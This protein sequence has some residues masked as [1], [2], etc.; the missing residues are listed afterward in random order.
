MSWRCSDS[1]R[2]RAQCLWVYAL[3]PRLDAGSQRSEVGDTLQLVIRQL[4][5]EV[6]LQACEKFECLQAVDSQ[7]LKEIVVGRKFFAGHFEVCSGQIQ[8]FTQRLVRGFHPFA[9][10]V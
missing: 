5:M 4:N 8:N 9:S 10:P 3:Q 7:L 6:I 1:A 2:K